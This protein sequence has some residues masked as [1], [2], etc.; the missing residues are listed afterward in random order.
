MTSRLLE[1]MGRPAYAFGVVLLVGCSSVPIATRTATAQQTLET[2]QTIS[3]EEGQLF[4]E[5]LVSELAIRR[6]ELEVAAEGYSRASERTDDPRV[7]ERATQL[8]IYREQ[9]ETAESAA[10][11]WLALDSEA[12][13]AHEALAQIHLRQGNTEAAVLA[14]RGWIDSSADKTEIFLLIN[15]LL[16]SNPQLELAYGVAGALA[17]QYPE[18][19]LAHVGK[20]QLALSLSDSDE[21]VAA[22][23]EALL[24][25]DTLV[26][27]L[28]VKAQV[29]ISQGRSPDAVETLQKAI[30]E[31]PDSLALHLG[32]AQLLVESRLY[33]RAGPVLEQA[34]QLSQGDAATWL[35]LG[36][37]ALTASR[38]DQA[39]TYLT[40]VLEYDSFNERAQFY[41][42]RI[43]DRNNDYETAIAHYDSVPQGEFFLT[44]RMR[45]AELSADGGDVESGVER[46]RELNSEA[47]DPAAKVQLIVSE[48]RMLQVAE[49]G[50]EAIDVLS[51]G[52]EEHPGD[53]ELLYARALAAEKNGNNQLFE[54]D[55][56]EV[57]KTDADNAHAMNALGYHFV[58]NN[59]RLDEAEVHLER[60]LELEPEDAAIIDSLGWLRFRQGRFEEAKELL[61]EAYAIYPDAEIA[62]H[63]GEVL[64]ALGDESGAKSLWDRALADEPEHV[65]LNDVVNRFVE[66]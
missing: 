52:L 62:A 1:L 11:R 18:Q 22:A 25:D 44:A 31:Q 19:P 38:N 21:A 4:Y 37:L 48:S 64:W 36:L 33:D 9:W 29:Q 58:V 42:G 39:K 60:A 63:L 32:F 30:T 12:V 27:A 59:I 35:R 40:G 15:G 46:L 61:S 14:F 26:D 3:E 10:N 56:V 20:A 13:G 41:L 49:R 51:V 43:A 55:L 17:D 23:E 66:N 2:Q 53:A 16:L 54:D 28:L 45:A 24:L 65:I 57:I 47:A 6:G 8:A 34:A 7:A 50:T 5:L